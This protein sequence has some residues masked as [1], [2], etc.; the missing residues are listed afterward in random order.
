MKLVTLGPKG[1]FSHQASK[2]A[3][4]NAEI[5][6][7]DSIDAVFFRL[8]EKEIQEAVVP[9]QNNRSGFVEETV[10]NLMKYDFSIRGCLTEKITHFLAGKGKPEEAKSLLAHPH[11]FAQCKETLDALG[12]HCKVVETLSN[13]HSAMQLKLDQKGETIAIV[14]PLAAEIYKLPVLKEHIEDDPENATTFLI[15]G[16]EVKK[17]TGNDCSA[18][19][20]F[21]DPLKAVE[22]Q[23]RALAKEKKCEVLKLENLLLQEGHTPLYF[24]E[25]TGHIFEEKVQEVIANLKQKFLLKHLGSYERPNHT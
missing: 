24:M 16:K 13:G 20:I 8:G 17:A 18:F 9:I 4:K 6:F 21:S 19:L 22:N 7:A 12:V 11:A 14:S 10:V 1:T 25:M 23:I 2:K 3:H 15:I 5:V